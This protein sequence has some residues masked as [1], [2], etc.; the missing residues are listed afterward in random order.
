M[1]LSLLLVLKNMSSRTSKI[2][3]VLQ[4][5]FDTW[6]CAAVMVESP[7]MRSQ[8]HLRFQRSLEI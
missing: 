1:D 4:S 3:D 7:L 5:N 6:N 8:F 2:Y